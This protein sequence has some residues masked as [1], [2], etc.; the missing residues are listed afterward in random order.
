M[1]WIFALVKNKRLPG[2]LVIQLTDRCNAACPQCGMRRSAAFPRSRL[3]VD[4]VKRIIDAAA[5][6][7]FRVVSFT[8]GEPL[9]LEDDLVALIAHAGR[10]G[11][12]YIRTGTNGFVFMG[13]ERPGFESR[14]HRLAERL[15]ATP[16]R[17]FWISIDSALPGVHESMRGLPGVVAGIEK[18]LTI[19]HAHGIYPAANLG[20]N[21]N[22]DGPRTRALSG[23]PDGDGAPPGFFEAFRSGFDAFFRF[24]VDLG[25]TMANACYPM[26]VDPVEAGSGL[27][28][29]YAATST[30]AVVRFSPGEKVLLFRALRQAVAEFRPRVRIFSP[31]CSLYALERQHAGSGSP[32]PC[33]G[34]IDFFFVDA[35]NGHTYPCGYRGDEDLGPLFDAGDPGPAAAPGC[36]RCDWECFRDPSELFGPLLQALSRPGGLC[37]RLRADP[38][39]FRLWLADL[40]YQRVCRFFDG[41]RAPDASGL[42]GF[43]GRLFVPGYRPT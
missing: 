12:T 39:F 17:N 25:F 43:K 35:K 14:V 9:L 6:R 40:A 20:V 27:S 3:S 13:A 31:L 28:A 4:G 41:R 29:A 19:F 30:D 23:L 22:L 7:G 33:R 37:R 38:R 24:V 11:M 2:Q 32:Y 1:H 26:S 10:A 15:A 18:A 42:R 8:G 5:V 16:L 36:T 34:G 21:R